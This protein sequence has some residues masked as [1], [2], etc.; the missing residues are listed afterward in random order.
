MRIN[1]IFHSLQGEGLLTGVPS[2]FI[3]LSGCP[4]R[5]DWCDT[6]YAQST[7]QGDPLSI[8]VVA[9]TVRDYC[10]SHIVI[11]GGEPMIAPDLPDLID[12]LRT[13][14]THITIE[15]SGIIHNPRVTCDL[16]SISPKL[17]NSTPR[18][19]DLARI[20]ESSRLDPA[21]LRSLLDHYDCQLKF[22]VD[23]PADL[24]EIEQLLA[25]IA[26]VN[27]EKVL[28]MPQAATRT[29]LI[30]KSPLVANLCKKSG[31]TFSQR[32]HLLL[33][34]SQRGT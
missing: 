10:C 3:R 2:V 14:D 15:T 32:L 17:S 18:D 31:L 20:H 23:S 16:M 9:R 7:E 13:P 29:E 12:A 30:E 26:P 34:D 19:S 28:L 8:D 11:T 24:D 25:R 27:R 33:W 1:E 6:Q 5:C 22:V 21:V 4:L